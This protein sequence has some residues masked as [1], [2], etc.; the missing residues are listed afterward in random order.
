VV[1]ELQKL[2]NAFQS[3]GDHW[4][5]YGYQKAINAIKAY[6]SEIKSYEVSASQ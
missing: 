5:A 6:G 1:A 2:V 4:R 3:A